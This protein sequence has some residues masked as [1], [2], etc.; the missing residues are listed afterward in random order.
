MY[1]D[2]KNK[3]DEAKSI[4]ECEAEVLKLYY[5]YLRVRQQLKEGASEYN[6]FKTIY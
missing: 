6:E 2:T 5:E 3:A 4:T 1:N